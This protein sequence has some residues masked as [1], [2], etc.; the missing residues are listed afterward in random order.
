MPPIYD[1]LAAR[2]DGVMQPL[3]RRFI[4]RWRAELFA[5]LPPLSNDARLLEVGAGT[6][7][8]FDFYPPHVCAAATEISFR[9]IEQASAKA[10]SSNI[11]F[12]QARAEALPFDDSTFDAAIAALVFCS[13][14]SPALAFAELHRVLRPGGAIALLEH[15]RPENRIL[16]KAFDALSF[17]TERIF[18]D[19][20]NRRTAEEARH[21]GFRNLRVK[22]RAGGVVQLIVAQ[23]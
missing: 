23:K 6:G 4:R 15:V 3:E 9:M 19:H 12:A 22:N 8:N 18:D 10:S 5:S 7:A 11:C 2:Y 17:F 14:T 16:G 13:V 21:A 20:F 1:K